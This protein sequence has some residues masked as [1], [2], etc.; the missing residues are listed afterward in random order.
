MS[1]RVIDISESAVRLSVRHEG[2]Q[3]RQVYLSG[4]SRQSTAKRCWYGAY[5][6]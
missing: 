1:D 6:G 5:A 4:D 3:C 2:R